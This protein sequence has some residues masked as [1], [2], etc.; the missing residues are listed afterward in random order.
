MC[1]EHKRS[2]DLG[3]IGGKSLIGP[4][5]VKLAC[6]LLKHTD[7]RQTP[8]RGNQ[9]L[10]HACRVDHRTAVQDPGIEEGDSTCNHQ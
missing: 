8:S 7:T 10:L 5:Q 2:E 9:S 4:E 1:L 3:S 6:P